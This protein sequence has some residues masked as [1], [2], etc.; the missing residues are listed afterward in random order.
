MRD[1]RRDSALRMLYE[2]KPRARGHTHLI[3]L[4][5]RVGVCVCGSD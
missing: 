5:V 3:E 1:L 2:L 4:N